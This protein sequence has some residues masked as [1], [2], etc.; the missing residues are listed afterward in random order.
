[1]LILLSDPFAGH[2]IQVS[3]GTRTSCAVMVE[4][5]ELDTD[6]S[7]TTTSIH[8]WGSRANALLDHFDGVDRSKMKKGEHKQI[9]LGQDH[10]CATTMKV[11]ESNND[12]PKKTALECWWLAGSDFDAHKVP[13]GH[14][15]IG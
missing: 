6:G 9:S 2:F 5:S 13:L 1:M 12:G 7:S 4:D 8:C 10:A 14:V 11:D 3:A 15:Q